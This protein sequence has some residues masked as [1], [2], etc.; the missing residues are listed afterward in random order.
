MLNTA[1]DLSWVAN[2]A[3]ALVLIGDAEPHPPRSIKKQIVFLTYA[4]KLIEVFIGETKLK[5]CTAI[6][7]L[8]YEFVLTIC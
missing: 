1:Y 6:K 2:H 4:V 7:A 3:K 8:R 5:D